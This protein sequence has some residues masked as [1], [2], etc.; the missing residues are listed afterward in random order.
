MKTVLVPI[1]LSATTAT[2]C[3]AAVAFARNVNG[4]LLF[5]HIVQPPVI[6]SDYG[7]AMENLEELVSVSE[8]SATTQLE[9]LKKQFETPDQPVE[10]MQLTGAPA[11]LI[12]EEARKCGADYIVM[13][14]HGHTALYD[15]L[16]GTTTHGVLKQANCP[17]L[18]IPAV[19]GEARRK[20]Q[21]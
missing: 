7:I 10:T 15:L 20:R 1:D 19:S 18:I 11:P 14:S 5:L 8:K 3:A 4:K 2:V 17:V 9:V 13:G 12:L 6:T 21:I 16:V